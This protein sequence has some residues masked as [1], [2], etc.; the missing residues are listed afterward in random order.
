MTRT[1]TRR[2]FISATGASAF[3]AAHTLR[4]AQPPV[5]RPNIIF[6]LADDLG[7]GDL[8]CYGRP[9]YRT[10]VLDQMA[11]QGV[12]FSTAYS[13]GAVCSPTRC[14]FVTGRYPQ[15]VDVGLY[16]PLTVSSADKGLAPD[17]PTLASLLKAN[18]YETAL[19]GK[20]HLGWKPE[21]GPNRHGFGEFFGVLS[22]AADYFTH[23]GDVRRADLWENLTP[24]K[25][26]GYMTDLLSDRAVEFI[27]R[28]RDRP[29]YLSLHYTAP[30]SPWE[31]PGDRTIDHTKHGPGPMIE[32]G[33]ANIFASMMKSLDDGIGRVFEA[34]H[35]GGL[36]R[37]TLVIFTSDNGGE[38]YSRNLPF[39]FRKGSL[40][41]GGIRVPAI[42]RWPGVVASGKTTDQAAI[43]MDWTSTILGAS[44]TKADPSFALDGEDL[45]P[46]CQGSRPIH[47]RT[48]FWR[49]QREGAA[50]VGNWKYIAGP[51]KE[52]LFDL[53]QDLGERN[54]LRAGRADE[55]ER[56]KAQ[57]Q[58]WNAAMLPR[59]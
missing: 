34:L 54:D 14:A 21:F 36:E 17:H 33:S 25:R 8:S 32:G 45:M 30:H 37:N 26:E 20:W 7:Y 19:I 18:G 44:G 31:G 52:Q 15:R 53:S 10:P 29:F 49:T 42:V 56:I 9:D 3:V 2:R 28:Q 50:R 58:T 12:R 39:S 4:A 40:F 5:Q 13:A 24:V 43:T 46:V 35:R 16:E 51:E 22:G 57:Y 38:R 55:F 41:E 47:E 11:T 48:L 1:I 6:I 59:L 23:G 27:S